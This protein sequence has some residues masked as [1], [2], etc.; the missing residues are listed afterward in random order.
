MC[1][2]GSPANAEIGRYDLNYA[3]DPIYQQFFGPEN[4]KYIKGEFTRLGYPE[5]RLQN[6]HSFM[7]EVYSGT[8][9]TGFDP[10]M[11][12]RSQFTV[13][14]L[15]KELIEYMVPIFEN[16]K[17]SARGYIMDQK[18]FRVHD[19]PISDDCRYRQ[20]ILNNRFP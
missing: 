13:A 17:C 20:V 16:F 19:Q 18:Y 8:T 15:N 4:A 7:V 1:D 11:C 14:N 9:R 12:V 10:S 2:F 6:L 3:W 5:V